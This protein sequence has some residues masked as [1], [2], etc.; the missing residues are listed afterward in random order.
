MYGCI[1]ISKL[2][3]IQ[4]VQSII[5]YIKRDEM[6]TKMDQ[7]CWVEKRRKRRSMGYSKENIKKFTTKFEFYQQLLTDSL[8]SNRDLKLWLTVN[9]EIIDVR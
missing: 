8:Q 4:I 1:K 7:I 5:R 2:L 9:E 6:T 3:Y